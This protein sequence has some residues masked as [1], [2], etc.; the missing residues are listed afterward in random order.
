MAGN[1]RLRLPETSWFFGS[2]VKKLTLGE[3][4]EQS[5]GQAGAYLENL[6]RN[7]LDFQENVRTLE[8]VLYVPERKR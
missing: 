1:L 8:E 5:R 2:P 7:N 4:Q 3:V 6:Y